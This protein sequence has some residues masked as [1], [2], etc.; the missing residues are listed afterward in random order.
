M[1]SMYS[2][3][4]IIVLNDLWMYHLQCGENIDTQMCSDSL[5]LLIA[6]NVF[7]VGLCLTRLLE[8][9]SSISVVVRDSALAQSAPRPMYLTLDESIRHD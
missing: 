7:K 6:E 3:S 8:S 1:G 5:S 9:S 4:L 2:A